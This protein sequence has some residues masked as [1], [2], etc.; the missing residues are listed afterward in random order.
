M[1][2]L[3]SQPYKDAIDRVV[4]RRLE[5]G[6]SQE[7][8]ARRL[9]R[10]QKVAADPNQPADESGPEGSGQLQSFVSKFE[11]RQ[12]RLDVIEFQH[13]CHVL[14]LRLCDV[15]P[16][17]EW[18]GEAP[19]SRVPLARESLIEERTLAPRRAR[20]GRAPG[21]VP[22]PERAPA[23]PEWRPGPPLGGAERSV[24]APGHD[25]PLAADAPEPGPPPKPKPEPRRKPGR[26]R[27]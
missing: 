14:G 5:L 7:E 6:W 1:T 2:A 26:G 22:L 9:P 12:R 21:E 20:P 11:Q 8:L 25:E 13:L 23:A 17:H 3:H 19:P 15:L 18:T 27:R 10:Y 24:E 4:Q 16:E